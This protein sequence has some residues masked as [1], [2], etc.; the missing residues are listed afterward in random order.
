MGD[1]WWQ[2]ARLKHQT[3]LPGTKPA[4]GRPQE[5]A[6]AVAENPDMSELARAAGPGQLGQ[7]SYPGAGSAA[8]S[9]VA[10]SLYCL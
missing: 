5:P 1:L 4:A 7:V 2:P 3:A 10:G 6:P 8:V 9:K